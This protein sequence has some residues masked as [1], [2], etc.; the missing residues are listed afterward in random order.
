MT[1]QTNLFSHRFDATQAHDAYY[2]NEALNL[3]VCHVEGV[4]NSIC[5]QFEGCNA[6]ASDELIA[7][8]VNAVC[9]MM[10]DMKAIINAHFDAVKAGKDGAQ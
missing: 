2:V 5:V 4:L 7:D 3:T 1:T 6:R 9:F 8:S 10:K